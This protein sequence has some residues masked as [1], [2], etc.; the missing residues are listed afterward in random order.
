MALQ[1]SAELELRIQAQVASGQFSTEE[2]VVRE[3]LDTLERQQ[4]SLRAL[5]QRV[6]EAEAD[7]QAGRIGP[8]DAEQTKRAVR[9]RLRSKSVTD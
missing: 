2:D 8:F 7:V 3:A 1:L 5:Q 6:Q 9:E 4:F